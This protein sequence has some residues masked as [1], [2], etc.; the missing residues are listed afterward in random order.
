MTTTKGTGS[1]RI[2]ETAQPFT[3]FVQDAETC[4]NLSNVY[5]VSEIY[6]AF[7]NWHT[8]IDDLLYVY[9]AH[10]DPRHKD[11]S[12]IR[13]FGI[14]S[15]HQLETTS[16]VYYCQMYFDGSE[17]VSV[18]ESVIYTIGEHR[19]PKFRMIELAC[20][21]SSDPWSLPPMLV[22]ITTQTCAEPNNHLAVRQSYK[23]GFKT[24]F[25]LC[26]DGVL[27]H[28]TTKSSL[29][30]EWIELNM[31]LGA[32][33]IFVY[34]LSGSALL[35]P[36]LNYY[37]RKGQ[38]TILPWN[39]PIQ[40]N[41]DLDEFGHDFQLVWN[42]AQTTAQN[43]CLYRNLFV[44]RHLAYLDFDEFIIPQEVDVWNWNDMMEHAKHNCTNRPGSYVA[45]NAFFLTNE[46][47]DSNVDEFNLTT[48]LHTT[49]NDRL[50]KPGFRSKHILIPEHVRHV[51]IHYVEEYYDKSYS[52]CV[53]LPSVGHLH[54]YRE[55]TKKGSKHTN[56]S[57]LKYKPYLI[58]QI[59]HV[60]DEIK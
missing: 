29:I 42:Y 47:N 34:N 43:D 7:D 58:R 17:N 52:T 26:L 37:E 25:T 4:P 59:H 35:D 41:E 13:I 28:G 22:S 16:P 54:H 27:K 14:I 23:N 20:N 44:A 21:V 36:Y 3:S 12:I 19:K 24:N 56:L 6:L 32:E 30:V 49:M 5:N 10:V 38:L 55:L 46:I 2:I 53:V 51:N 18:I 45:R 33:H 9:S 15:R 39:I 50:K 57:A 1:N 11:N 8:V 31:L 60:Y 48:S 40:F